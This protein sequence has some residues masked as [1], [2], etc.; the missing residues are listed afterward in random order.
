MCVSNRAG[1]PRIFHLA[2]CLAARGALLT[3]SLSVIV[4]VYNAEAALAP[5]VMRL[6]ELLPELTPR[7]EICVVDDGS[8]DHTADAAADLAREFPQV[9]LARH[10]WQWGTLAAARTGR[11]HCRGDVVLVLDALEDF[12]PR[13]L[14]ARWHEELAKRG[15]AARTPCATQDAGTRSRVEAGHGQFAAAFPPSFTRHLRRLVGRA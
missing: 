9:R 8:T 11:M 10:G 13:E 6:L 7:F 3:P 15:M 14:A 2:Y 1:L 12:Q 5:L 4:P